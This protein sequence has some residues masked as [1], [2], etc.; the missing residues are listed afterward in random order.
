MPDLGAARDTRAAVPLQ[1]EDNLRSCGDD[2]V[3]LLFPN[4]R[5]GHGPRRSRGVPHAP[6]P[7]R[8]S[9]RLLIIWDRLPAHRSRLVAEFVHCLE[10]E[11]QIEY[12]PA[13]APELNPVEYLW[14]HSKHHE[15]PN[16][17]PRDLWRLSEDARR[18]LRRL[19]RRP[20]LI[21]FWKQASL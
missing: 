19:R 14:G 5:K 12:L 16:V 9:G 3:E 17:C 15:L 13:Y 8:V 1:L 10:G 20:T 4:L 21:A 7:A 6:A 18:T 2:L 11:I